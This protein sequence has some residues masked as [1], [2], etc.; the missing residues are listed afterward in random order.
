MNRLQHVPPKLERNMI[1]M[2]KAR[3]ACAKIFK[4]LRRRQ[5]LRRS[6]LIPKKPTSH[7]PK[8]C[9]RTLR[10]K[11]ASGRMAFILRCQP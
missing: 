5:G 10:G 4:K 2:S 11:M 1:A 3:L 7:R 9:C 6:K 8:H